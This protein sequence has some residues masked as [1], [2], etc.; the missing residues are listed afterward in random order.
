[1]SNDFSFIE[2]GMVYTWQNVHLQNWQILY[3]I[4]TANDSR[5]PL[6]SNQLCFLSFLGQEVLPGG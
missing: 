2:A 3:R 4:G 5:E 1:M 6:P